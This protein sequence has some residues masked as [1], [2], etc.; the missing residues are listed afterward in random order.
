MV[1]DS[2]R[3]Q[4]V[5]ILKAIG[6]ISIVI[7]HSCWSITG[8]NILIGP[9]VYSYHLMIFMVVSGYLYNPEKI[10]NIK[11]LL[12]YIFKLFLKMLKIFFLYNLF[13]VVMHNIFLE[14][15]MI[16]GNYY[17]WQTISKNIVDG[18]LFKST[19]PFMGA[20]WFIYMML[21]SKIL[22]N[23]TSFI[24]KD[25]KFI[26]SIIMA[27]YCLI[28]LELCTKKIFLPYYFQISLI[29]TFFM[30]IGYLLKKNVNVLKKFLYKYGWIPSAIIIYLALLKLNSFIDLS[31]DMIINPFAF[32]VLTFIGIYFCFSLAKFIATLR[33]KKVKNI[34]SL[35]GCNSLHIMALH[36]MIIKFIDII[37]AK[38][39]NITDI[40]V[41][42]KFPYAFKIWYIY[43]PIAVIFSL[44]IALVIKK[45]NK[46]G[47]LMVKKIN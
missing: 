23:I 28:G 19:E 16:N 47:I 7:G 15:N 35:I 17:S 12:K 41:I 39:F 6:I 38:L 37:Y 25:K 33:F 20:F 36:F 2:K 5:D 42:A 22:Y 11:E 10:N 24:F 29:A 14:L 8:M 40:N 1:K 13:F 45:I 4:F 21:I 43:V 30:Y 9:F 34:F 18:L 31:A 26:F 46:F 32:I 44:L 3:N 27:C